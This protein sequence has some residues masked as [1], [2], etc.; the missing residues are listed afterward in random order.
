MISYN[1]HVSRME[2][3]LNTTWTMNHVFKNNLVQFRFLLF[4]WYFSDNYI[5]H[6]EWL[7]CRFGRGSTTYVHAEDTS[8]GIQLHI[9]KQPPSQG[10]PFLKN[11]FFQ[12]WNTL[13]SKSGRSFETC[14]DNSFDYISD[15]MDYISFSE[16]YLACQT[17]VPKP[18]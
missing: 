17:S 8:F 7:A 10:S 1:F 14:L 16:I 6:S 12:Q 11:I 5:I 9:H 4:I 3:P 2:N 13:V 15:K 18:K